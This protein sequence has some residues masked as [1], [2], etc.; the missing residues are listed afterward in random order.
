[1]DTQYLRSYAES[2]DANTLA[3]GLPLTEQQ[4]ALI[5]QIDQAPECADKQVFR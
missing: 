2:A 4:R 1:M 3:H 5:A